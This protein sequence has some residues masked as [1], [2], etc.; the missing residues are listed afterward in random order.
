M[1]YIMHFKRVR[2]RFAASDGIRLH[3]ILRAMKLTMVFT[4]IFIVQAAASVRSQTLTMAF[5]E[6]KLETVLKEIK[7]QS[8]YNF[9]IDVKLLKAAPEV[10]VRCQETDI[11]AVLKMVFDDYPLQYQLNGKSIIIKE[12]LI[13][14][15]EP[16]QQQTI[17]GRVTDSLGNPLE[18][19]TVQLI[20]TSIRT[21]TDSNG[22]YGFSGAPLGATLLFRMLSYEPLELLVDRSELNV[23]L[24]FQ[25]SYL[26]EAEVRGY[27]NTTKKTS[28]GNARTITSE[29][30]SSQPVT[31][32]LLTLQG[33]VAGLSITQNTGIP[34]RNVGVA[35]RGRNSIANGNDPLFVVDG[36]PFSSASLMNGS[37]IGNSIFTG[38][39]SPLNSLNTENIESI[40]VLKDAD[41]TAI[42][43]SMGANGVI[44]IATKTGSQNGK[45]RIN[46]DFYTGFGKPTGKMDLMNTEQYLEL[47]KESFANSGMQPS[48]R[49]YDINGTWDETRYTDWQKELIGNTARTTSSQLRFSGGNERTQF[50]AGGGYNKETTVYPGDFFDRKL[51]FQSSFKHKT[52]N[53]NFSISITAGYS[54]NQNLMP[55][56]DLASRITLPPN[57]PELFDENGDLNWENETWTNPL[58]QLNS[59]NKTNTD[60]YSA[61]GFLEFEVVKDLRFKVNFGFNQI[62][63]KQDITMPLSS[64]APS[65]ADRSSLRRHYMLT[66]QRTTWITE[67][68]LTYSKRIGKGVIDALGG[69]TFRENRQHIFGLEASDFINDEL[70]ENVAAASSQHVNSYDNIQYRYQAI[71]ARIG[72]NWREKY[73]INLTGRRD[74]SSRF[75]P[76]NQF[77]NF[78]A[79]G[80]AWLLSE[81]SFMK[82]IP[83]VNFAKLRASYGLTGN[84]QLGDY[85]YLSTYSVDNYVYLTNTGLVPT[86]L[87]NPDYG[88]ESVRK[89]EFGLDLGLF[90]DQLYFN[91]SWYQNR[92]GNQLVGFPLST[93]TGFN[94]IRTNLPAIVQNKGTEFELTIQPNFNGLFRWTAA[95]NISFPR[96]KLLSYPDFESSNY[97]R[98]YAVGK[99]MYGDYR[100]LFDQVDPTTGLFTFKD[101]DGDGRIT[102]SDMLYI[103]REQRYYGGLTNN[104]TFK[105]FSL[106]IHFQF[107]NQVT[108]IYYDIP[109]FGLVNNNVNMLNRWEKEGDQHKW[110]Q[111]ISRDW[112]DENS[113]FV[114]SDALLA[115]AS[116]IR[117]KN[118]SLGYRLP[119]KILKPLTIGQ[120]ELYIE[121]Q[122]LWTVTKYGDA[123]PETLVGLHIPPIRMFTGG[124][125]LIL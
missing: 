58:A 83:V 111:K 42:Y 67:P 90:N 32:P 100:Y 21:S 18:G 46:A 80:L 86:R 115:D 44:L 99:S 29:E 110:H 62:R 49:D 13:S 124:I 24:K 50:T 98:I 109:V 28:T 59:K 43:G 121:G 78:G 118:I 60:N 75:G 82:E 5:H 113:I 3:N 77:G 125:K 14:P 56:T 22:E 68:Q 72:Y 73:I 35:I 10:T 47:R 71:Y 104:I 45:V 9:I 119:Q 97:R 36:V 114:E 31:N 39:Q 69:M 106:S 64:F 23:V 6:A 93:V 30:I 105:Q 17:H 38:M 8:G 4:L 2:G 89:L 112:Y 40:T 57:A 87:N 11:K 27:Y 12:R 107:V 108:P 95:G 65:S 91:A 101:T 120:L 34:G 76:S 53:D 1:D 52:P 63:L 102:T 79:M 55:V 81:E 66:N 123:D 25:Y 51:S 103:E 41:A 20:G 16:K 61:S 74:G 122:N 117:L 92:T 15:Y 116:F 70:I 88:W 54:N 48:A 85:E 96:N 26:N 33:R 84:D 94:T 37:Y 19:V 7:A